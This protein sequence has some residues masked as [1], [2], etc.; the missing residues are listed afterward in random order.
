MNIFSNFGIQPILLLA[1]IVN[2]L[3]LLYILKRFLYGPIL[4]VLDERKKRVT[5]SLKDAE[6]IERSLQKTQEESDKKFNQAT[7]EARKIIEE[8]TKDANTL[9]SD[10]RAKATEAAQEIMEKSSQSIEFQKEKMMKE[11]RVEVADLV[12][13]SLQKVTGKVLNSQDQKDLIESSLKEMS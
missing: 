2:F 7:L 3:V 9:L 10:A 11:V 8:A 12:A 4:K 13:M 1:Q 5:Q 6:E